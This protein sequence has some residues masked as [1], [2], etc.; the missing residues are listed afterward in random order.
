MDSK[1]LVARGKNKLNANEVWLLTRPNSD[2]KR[3]LWIGDEPTELRLDED[4]FVH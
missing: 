4:G 3:I 1:P 2:S